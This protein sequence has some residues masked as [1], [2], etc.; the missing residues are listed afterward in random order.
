L[1]P[2]STKDRRR[3]VALG[4]KLSQLKESELEELSRYEKLQT[5]TKLREMI[6]RMWKVELSFALNEGTVFDS[7]RGKAVSTNANLFCNKCLL[8]SEGL[9]KC[10]KTV[11][12]I[13]QQVKKSGIKE[14]AI[15]DQCHVGFKYW[16]LPVYSK[17]E[18]VGTVMAG[19]FLE[20]APTEDKRKIILENSGAYKG[21]ELADPQSAIDNIPILEPAQIESLEE[22]ISFGVEEVWRYHNDT[23]KRRESVLEAPDYSGAP[24][25]SKFVVGKSKAMQ[26]LFTLL[27]KLRDSDS[28]VL[29]LGENGTGKE[30]VAKAIHYNSDRKVK[31]FVTQNCSALNDNLLDS[32]L[33]GHVR[34]S[35][36]GAVRDKKGL[37]EIANGGTF[38]MDEV[39]DMS[40][41]LQVKLLRVLQEGMFIPVGGTEPRFV[42]V[43]IIAATNRNLR[44]MVETGEFR[45]DLYYR[46]NVITIAVPPLRDRREDI[47]VLADY[48]LSK[49]LRPSSGARKIISPE[50]FDAL[51]AF[52]WPGNVRQLENEIQRAIVLAGK[53][54]I[55]EREMLSQAVTSATANPFPLKVRGK[56]K[57]A[58]E[59]VER[60]I[61]LDGLRRHAWNKSRLSKE[62]GVSRATLIWKIQKY[63]LAEDRA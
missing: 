18:L 23:Q 41:A 47:S 12:E 36:T 39:G 2:T 13:V 1:T 22:M 61:I 3:P 38:F 59:H 31:A 11:K 10:D 25:G 60:Q 28:T 51:V 40:P 19:G 16:A 45:E 5:V 35:F 20:S 27:D 30:L 55:I 56:L 46:L 7:S 8:D 9:K 58:M 44:A 26:D 21:A 14:G 57:D 48:F 62:L 24:F 52:N 33:F 42:D 17:D 43:R 49:Y 32:E 15:Y 6:R 34:G 29:I 50:A 54:Q 63:G 53:S 4:G 37:F